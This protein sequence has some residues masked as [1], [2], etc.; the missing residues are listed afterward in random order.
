MKTIRRLLTSSCQSGRSAGTL[1]GLL[2]IAAAAPAALAG[3]PGWAHQAAGFQSNGAVT[4]KSLAGGSYSGT[5]NPTGAVAKVN[6]TAA[7]QA[8][9][10]IIQATG[11]SESEMYGQVINGGIVPTCM[12][13]FNRIW[14]ITGNGR[15]QLAPGVDFISNV[16]GSKYSFGV[17]SSNGTVTLDS[18][19]KEL[20]QQRG[21]TPTPALTKHRTICHL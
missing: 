2:A 20:C 6:Q 21:V 13:G 7:T 14:S 18:Y 10:V 4:V 17:Y 12:A 5:Q 8:P 11:T 19:T 1:A 15:D 3:P 16:A 9:T